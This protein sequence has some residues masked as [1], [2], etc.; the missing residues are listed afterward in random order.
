MVTTTTSTYQTSCSNGPNLTGVARYQNIARTDG[1]LVEIAWTD[2]TDG[3]F[4]IADPDGGLVER[5][6][7]VME[8]PWAAVCQVHGSTIVDA[9]ECLDPSNLPNADGIVTASVNTPISVQGADC[10][11]IVFVTAAG[12][13]GVAHAGW[14]GL[15]A[16]IIGKMLKTLDAN[17]ATTVAAVVGPVICSDCYE[18][19]GDDLDEVASSVGECVRSRTQSGTPAL[20]MRAGITSAFQQAGISNISFVGGCPACEETGFSH[21]ARTD[22]RRHCIVARVRS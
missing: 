17:R 21:R 11:P 2:T 3:D 9:A 4:H 19:G 16:G 6:S 7:K 8:G 20:D 5:R 12:P 18:F 10:A 14:R 13:I 15:S 22:P 1:S